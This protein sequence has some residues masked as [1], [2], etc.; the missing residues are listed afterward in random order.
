LRKLFQTNFSMLESDM[1]MR[2]RAVVIIMRKN[3]YFH[4]QDA[5]I[6][7]SYDGFQGFSKPKVP[8][9]Y[10]R[11]GWGVALILKQSQADQDFGVPILFLSEDEVTVIREAFT[12]SDELTYNLLGHGWLHGKRPFHKLADFM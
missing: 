9:V 8:A 5:V 12:K 7:R 11:N 1:T 2:L 3:G 10:P 4:T 6:Y